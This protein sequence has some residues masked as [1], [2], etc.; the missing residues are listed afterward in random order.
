VTLCT[1]W[2]T[3]TDLIACGCPENADPG[4][5]NLAIDTASELLY[6]LTA[7]QF[8]GTC[9]ATVRPCSNPGSPYAFNWA[10]WHYPWVALRVDGMW[11]N[12]GPCGCNMAADCGCAPY[13]RVNFGRSD[14]L[15]VT[16]VTIDGDVLPA[17]DYRLDQSQYLVRTD[18]G[19]W[20]C[21][22]NLGL[23]LGEEGTWGVELT[24]GQEP[25]TPVTHAAAVL[26]AEF[27]KACTGGECRL[28]ARTQTV[29]KQGVTIGFLDPFDFLDRGRTGLF[30][31]DL[32][33]TSYNPNGLARRGRVL[34]P[35]L[36]RALWS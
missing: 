28:P 13:P 32:V 23:D 35:E 18:G 4:V 29:T 27:V 36:P 33:I 34:S 31:V 2:I 17:T 30:E 9:T 16:E 8:P 10:V 6:A 11:L 24:Y 21:C 7:R 20:P 5:L 26:A 15:G 1:P 19:K 25:P 22:Q 3:E 14:I 12:L